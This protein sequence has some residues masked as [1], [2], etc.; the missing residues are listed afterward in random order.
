M[1]KIN[2]QV[3]IVL[4]LLVAVLF[5]NCQP[6]AVKEISVT[7][8]P[9]SPVVDAANTSSPPKAPSV[10]DL[11]KSC[12]EA[13]RLGK[14]R[15]Y[16]QEITFEDPKQVCDWGINGNADILDGQVRARR[17]QSQS[18]SIPEGATICNI[19]MDNVDQ[20][21]FYY[22][23]NIILTINEYIIA[24]TTDFS[25]YFQATDGYYKY[26]WSALLFKPAQ[27]G[28][29]DSTVDKQYCAGKSTGDSEC[30]FPQTQTVGNIQ[31]HIGEKVI[32]NILGITS[33]N[34]LK[35]DMITTGDNDS[36]DCQHVPVQ[37]NIN[38]DYFIQ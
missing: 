8:K 35:I 27:N 15:S 19:K 16:T 30:L 1:K 4:G 9:G 28:A 33:P 24:S 13:N 10:T 17:E 3:Y 38:V 20:Q 31:L 32:Q 23:D 12:D 21:N 2:L 36:T 14:L 25:K 26:D 18:V 5:Q 7:D 11:M 6:I 37:F 34:K 29:M 22:D